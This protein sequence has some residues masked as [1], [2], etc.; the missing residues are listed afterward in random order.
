MFK[1][2]A[3]IA[4]ASVL[5]A[6]SLPAEASAEKKALVVGAGYAD[7]GRLD[8]HRSTAGQ[9]KGLMRWMFNGLVRIELGRASPEPV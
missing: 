5:G 2:L 7:A 1:K 6:L 8:L 4:F 9:D 3:L